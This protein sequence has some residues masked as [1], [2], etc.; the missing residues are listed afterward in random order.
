MQAIA[1]SRGLCALEFIKP[2]RQQLL[3]R[4]LKQW[5]PSAHLK[6]AQ[7]PLLTIARNWLEAY[8]D[9]DFGRLPTLAIDSRGTAFEIRVWREMRRLEPGTT[10]S[11]SA[12]AARVGSPRGFRA[13]G[14]ASR[15][16]PIALVVPCHRVVGSNGQLTGYGGGLA[17]KE[18]LIGHER[19]S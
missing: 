6:T 1:S 15:S 7:N 17:H 18:W 10:I 3:D 13:V 5:F 14:N 16:N 19:R 11:Y 12:L 9:S 2:D 8:F 4:R